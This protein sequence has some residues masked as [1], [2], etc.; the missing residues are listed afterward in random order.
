[1]KKKFFDDYILYCPKENKIWLARPD[2]NWGKGWEWFMT[3]GKAAKYPKAKPELIEI[4]R[5]PEMS[6]FDRVKL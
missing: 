6:M 4:D 2:V 1:M 3:D 5:M